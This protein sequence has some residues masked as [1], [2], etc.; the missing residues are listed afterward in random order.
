MLDPRWRGRACSCVAPT[1]IVAHIRHHFGR[2]DGRFGVKGGEGS[3]AST[4]ST[5]AAESSCWE[6]LPVECR[7]A[8]A[9]LE[10]TATQG[11]VWAGAGALGSGGCHGIIYG[12]VWGVHL[13]ELDGLTS[14]LTAQVLLRLWVVTITRRLKNS[15]CSLGP[16]TQTGR[17]VGAVSHCLGGDFV[18]Q[19]ARCLSPREQFFVEE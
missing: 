1:H 4:E 14:N 11:T 10:L 6:T 18:H 12:V 7:G 19:I 16:E 3:M 2:L 9:W 13:T 15:R 5:I 17:D 8:A